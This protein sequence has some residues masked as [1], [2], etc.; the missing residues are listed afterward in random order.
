MFVTADSKGQFVPC[1]WPG[2][3]ERST[4]QAHE[5]PSC[6]H[7]CTQMVGIE[8]CC[9]CFVFSI[10]AVLGDLR[11]NAAYQQKQSRNI[12]A[13]GCDVPALRHGVALV[14]LE[15]DAEYIEV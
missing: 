12:F 11:V 8:C 15:V 3:Q 1:V 9:C 14:V 10:L 7:E 6:T 4:L 5:S 2:A 13:V